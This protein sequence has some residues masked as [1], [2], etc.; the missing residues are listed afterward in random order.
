VNGSK[1]LTNANIKAYVDEQLEKMSNE[2][3]AN[4]QE[5]VEYLTSVLRGESEADV[6][7][8]EGTGEGCS[9]ARTLTKNPDEKERLKATELLGKRYS[10]YSDKLNIDGAFN[11]VF[12]G[13]NELE[14]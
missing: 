8:V 3:V 13:E 5:V 11:V 6:V 10:L 1:L 2:R 9:S 4:A 7:V 12:G 14:D